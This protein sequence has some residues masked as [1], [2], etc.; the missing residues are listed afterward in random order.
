MLFELASQYLGSWA[1]HCYTH[2]LYGMD[3]GN[4]GGGG[5]GMT[6]KVLF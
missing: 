4:Y 2:I 1:V 6:Y 5:G 3:G